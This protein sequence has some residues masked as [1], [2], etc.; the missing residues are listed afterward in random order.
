MPKTVRSVNADALK[1][2]V[3]TACVV[4]LEGCVQ[5]P[6]LYQGNFYISAKGN[7]LQHGGS[8]VT[9][10]FQ[11][12]NRFQEIWDSI[13]FRFASAQTFNNSIVFGAALEEDLASGQVHIMYFGPK[14]GV[15]DIT[16]EIMR[17]ASR[18]PT[19]VP[20]GVKCVATPDGVGLTFLEE[21]QK[22]SIT[23]Q[24]LAKCAESMVEKGV[25][26]TLRKNKYVGKP[27]P[28]DKTP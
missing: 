12:N 6:S 16:P 13:S 3:L 24:A 5:Q 28:L 17:L 27:L 22:I 15:V 7:S 11:E 14:I 9:L 26:K 10:Y 8:Y 25:I 18:S 23:S 2:I 20:R 4:L 21:G 1:F 19:E